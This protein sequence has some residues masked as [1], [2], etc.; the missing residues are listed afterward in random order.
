MK[1]KSESEFAQLCL[2]P[3]DPMD[4]S[5]PGSSVHGI[6][7]ARVLLQKIKTQTRIEME[8]IMEA[9]VFLGSEREPTEGRNYRVCEVQ[10][11]LL[12]HRFALLARSRTSL[13]Y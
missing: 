3:S 4:C 13:K 5:L 6:F 1:V 9:T 2:G 12:V 7:Q 8:E 11:S 10:R